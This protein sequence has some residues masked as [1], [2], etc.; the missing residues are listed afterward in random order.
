MR[1]ITSVAA[2]AAAYAA[3]AGPA[4]AYL[5]GATGSI[6]LQALIAGAAT[7]AVFGRTQIARLKQIYTNVFGGK[8]KSQDTK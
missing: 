8:A 3:A 2:L 6:I 5:D 4:L 7:I 1:R